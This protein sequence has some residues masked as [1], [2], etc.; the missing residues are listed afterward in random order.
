MSSDNSITHCP[1]ILVLSHSAVLLQKTTH[2]LCTAFGYDEDLYHRN[3]SKIEVGCM[4]NIYD[5]SV[6]SLEILIALVG[7]RSLDMLLVDPVA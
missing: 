7:L 4:V 1:Q 6:P 5:L 2:N 3:L